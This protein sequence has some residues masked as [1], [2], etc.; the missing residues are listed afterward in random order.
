MR[1]LTARAGIHKP[2]RGRLYQHDMQVKFG[3]LGYTIRYHYERG[4]E[5]VV[6]LRMKHQR[7]DGFL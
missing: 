6:I 2:V 7:E 1:Q 5:A 4:G 3:S